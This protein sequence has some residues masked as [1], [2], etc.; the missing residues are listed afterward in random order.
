MKKNL[1]SILLPL[2]VLLP[3]NMLAQSNPFSSKGKKS[4]ADN[5]APIHQIIK[6]RSGKSSSAEFKSLTF[7]FDPRLQTLVK[8][9]A[10]G[11]VTS[12]SGNPKGRKAL[13][14]SKEQTMQSCYDYLNDISGSTGIKNPASQFDIINIQDDELGHKHIKLQQKYLGVPIYGAEIIIHFKNGEP[15]FLNGRFHAETGLKNATPIYGSA[16][17]ISKTTTDLEGVTTLQTFSPEQKAL[18]DYNAP[19]SELVIHKSNDNKFK[20]AWHISIRPNVLEIWDYFIDANSGDVLQKYN[21]TCS[22]GTPATTT[23]NDLNGV[24]RAINS[25]QIGSTY[26]MINS[27]K[28]MFNLGTSVMP[29]QPAGAI[30]TLD[31]QNT[32][33]ASLNQ[34]TSTSNT[35]TATA[36]SA[37]YN[38]GVCFD[39]YKTVH[40]RNSLDG[41]GGTIISVINVTQNGQGMDNA[42]WNGKFMAYGNGHLYFKPLAGGLDVAAHEMTHGVISNTANLEYLN[43]SGAINES[44]ADVFGCMVD[45]S[46]W[47]IGEDVMLGGTYFPSGAL[48]DLSDPHN[49]GTSSDYYWQPR[50]VSEYVNTSQDNGGV[51]IN[52]GIPNYAYYLFATSAGMTKY[53]AQKVYY[54]AL[55]KY[56]VRSSQFIDLRIAVIQATTDL[57]GATEI[58]AAGAAF[59]AV[60]IYDGT[61]GNYQQNIPAVSGQEYML[62][63]N[64]DTNDPN[65]LY[66]ADFGGSS[67][68][69][70]SNTPLREK[71]SVTDDGSVAY[72]ADTLGNIRKITLDVSNPVETMLTNDEAW[73]H[74]AVSKDGSKLAATTLFQDT[75]IYIYDFSNS[76]WSRFYLYNPTFSPGITTD[77][78]IYADVVEWD[79]T[80]EHLIYDCYNKVTNGSSKIDYW[81]MGIIKV[82]DN[83]KDSLGNGNIQKIFSQLESGISVGN[84]TFSRNSPYIIAFDYYDAN[85]STGAIMASNIQ[86]DSTSLIC[87]TYTLGYPTYSKNDDIIAFAGLDVSYNEDI[88]QIGVKADKISPST[89]VAGTGLNLFTLPDWYAKGSRV[90]STTNVKKSSIN[91]S[92]FPNPAEDRITV[93]YEV[94]SSSLIDISLINALGQ[95]I[96][97][98]ISENQGQGSY[99]YDFSLDDIADGTYMLKVTTGEESNAYKIV[100]IK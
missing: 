67:L 35:W 59:D 37:H 87:A 99:N 41:Q 23:S 18:L 63:T 65:S 12:I 46:N 32:D 61:G 69:P 29:S 14:G 2:S 92:V 24:S 77:G 66:I 22:S 13:F 26:Y 73:G 19:N 51:H 74:V 15:H 21:H 54:R 9:S 3:L 50:K 42:Y 82:W 20:L 30:W 44:M 28:S 70:I 71:P 48:R 98:L 16:Y 86:T 11:Q 56:L 97:K 88:F 79:F 1:L 55:D 43:E 10:D 85:S 90:T 45:S 38:A 58:A 62:V 78:P 8:K 31:A 93:K 100:K 40:N 94:F 49:G 17:A 39:Y 5:R 25:W 34:I 64:T 75:S 91:L 7:P 47:T 81:D 33:L 95:P 52:S 27:T 72:F 84:P 68:T 83:A 76:T 57:Y 36:T 80:S 4:T 6:G 60:E 53:K 89:S 96:K